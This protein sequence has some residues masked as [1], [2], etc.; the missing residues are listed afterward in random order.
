MDKTSG[1]NIQVAVPLNGRDGKGRTRAAFELHVAYGP[2]ATEISRR[3]R[4]IKLILLAA[5][6]LFFAAV[7]PRLLS[8]SRALRS[9]SDPARRLLVRELG[10]AIDEGGLRLD[11]QPKVNLR[12]GE[13]DSVEALLRW[14]HPRNG[15]Y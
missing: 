10:R 14:E 8:A 4:R 15:D 6:A 2:V 1:K 3:S 7:F 12:T 5:A 9:Q 11:Y 13:V